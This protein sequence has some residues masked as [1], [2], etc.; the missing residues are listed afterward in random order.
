M[1]VIY[2]NRDIWHEFFQSGDAP[3]QIRL[4]KRHETKYNV[5]LFQLLPE[6]FIHHPMPLHHLR[7]LR[8]NGAA[9]CTKRS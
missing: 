4:K 2:H 1:S 6:K 9:R 7:G 3:V 8:L 5:H